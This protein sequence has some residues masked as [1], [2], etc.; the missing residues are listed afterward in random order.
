MTRSTSHPDMLFGMCF[1]PDGGR[2]LIACGNGQA[3]L[4]DWQSGHLVC[5]PGCG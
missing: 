5:S 3:S 4:W 1:A 2:V